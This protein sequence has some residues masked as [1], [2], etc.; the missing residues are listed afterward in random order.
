MPRI[1]L[2]AE[3]LVDG[4]TALRPWRDSDV[5]ALVEA[6]GRT[7]GFTREALLRSYFAHDGERHDMIAYGLLPGE[8]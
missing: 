5:P 2:A 6:G 8:I 1:A 4:P 7:A 3:P